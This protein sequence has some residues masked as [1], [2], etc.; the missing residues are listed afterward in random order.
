MFVVI[1]DFLI[2]KDG[3][4]ERFSFILDINYVSVN[5]V[6]FNSEKKESQRWRWFGVGYSNFHD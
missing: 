2:C 5:N 1:Y 6:S 3:H 4:N